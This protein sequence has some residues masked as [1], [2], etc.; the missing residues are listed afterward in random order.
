LI[1]EI[2]KSSGRA[3]ESILDKMTELSIEIKHSTDDLS[4]AKPAQLKESR[5]IANQIRNYCQ[6]RVNSISANFWMN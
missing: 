5:D 1:A 2:K 4:K 3:I 6:Q